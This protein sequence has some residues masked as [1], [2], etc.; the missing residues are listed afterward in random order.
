MEAS[1]VSGINY[2]ALDNIV[3]EDIGLPVSNIQE[4]AIKIYPNPAVGE[5]EI[6]GIDDFEIKIIDA[7]G[8]IVRE[9]PVVNQK[10]DVS[11]FANGVYYI[12]IKT[13]NQHIT[14]RI[15]KL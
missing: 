9:Q 1:I 7:F 11:D 4:E 8:R 6:T 2:L 12:F 13:H 5:I 3:I 14:K 15:I 10:V